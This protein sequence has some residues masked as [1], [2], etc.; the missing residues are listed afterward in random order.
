MRKWLILLFVLPATASSA[1]AWT[2]VDA[3]GQVHFSDRPVPGAR[4][5]ELAAAQGFGVALSGPRASGVAAPGQAGA[6]PYESIEILSPS[7]QETL[8]NIGGTVNVAVQFRPALQAGHRYDIAFD[9]QRRNLNSANPRATLSDVFRG[10]H[11][12]QI[13]VID[14]AGVEVMRSGVRNFF[15]QQ[16]SIQNPNNPQRNNSNANPPG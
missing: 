6:P 14:S 15:V 5:V 8:F 10:A 13:V 7:D 9:G 11:T 4:Q 16:T 3:N 1:P 12:L 2:W